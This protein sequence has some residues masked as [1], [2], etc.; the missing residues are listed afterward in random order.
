MQ[1]KEAQREANRLR[2]KALE[3]LADR[4]EFMQIQSTPTKDPDWAEQF[5]KTAQKANA[6]RRK[7]TESERRD[8]IVKEL[9]RIN[10][11]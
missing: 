8:E 1:T 7:L 3:D 5:E 6:L 10:E 11:K 4:I 9:S 2:G